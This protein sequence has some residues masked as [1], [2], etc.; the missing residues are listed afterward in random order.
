M[1]L[2]SISYIT[3]IVVT[4]YYSLS[5]KRTIQIVLKYK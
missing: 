3:N 2:T 5:D 4:F 1:G